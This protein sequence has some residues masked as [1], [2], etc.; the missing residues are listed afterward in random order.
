[1]SMQKWFTF[2]D[3]K[4]NSDHGEYSSSIISVSSDYNT[5]FH[6]KEDDGWVSV[7]QTPN[8]PMDGWTMES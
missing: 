7:S 2:Y 1:M 3:L 8:S 5:V 6:L 4:K